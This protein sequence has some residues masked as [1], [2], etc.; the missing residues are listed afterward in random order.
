[1]N[2]ATHTAAHTTRLLTIP[3]AARLLSVSPRS[4]KRWIAAG[5]FPVV[6]LGER[7]RDRRVPEAELVAWVEARKAKAAA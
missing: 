6:R 1:M 5:S 3:D 4:V 2:I 7:Q